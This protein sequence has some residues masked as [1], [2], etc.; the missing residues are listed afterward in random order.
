MKKIIYIIGFILIVI[1][2]YENMNR[3]SDSKDKVLHI[4]VSRE[5]YDVLKEVNPIFES[6]HQAQI[7]MQIVSSEQV[8]STLPLYTASLEYTAVITASNTLMS[9]L[10]SKNAISP[11]SEVFETLNIL[12]ILM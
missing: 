10:V 11:I 4:W 7:K 6:L 3:M 2:L 5:E 1:G 12:P 9:E 8:I